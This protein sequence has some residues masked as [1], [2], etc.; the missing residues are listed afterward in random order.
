MHNMLSPQPP[1]P[2]IAPLVL[3][4]VALEPSIK[5]LLGLLNGLVLRVEVGSVVARLVTILVALVAAAVVAAPLWARAVVV[6]V[7]PWS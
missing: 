5:R 6:P 4:V 1:S 2:T 7:E 3:V